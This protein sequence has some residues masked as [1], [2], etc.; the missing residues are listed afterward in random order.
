MSDRVLLVGNFLSGRVGTRAVVEEL[1][2]RLAESGWQVVTTSPQMGRISRMVDMVRTVWGRRSDYDVA[3]IDVFS[4][5]SFVW[6]EVVA[7]LLR[8]L[9]KPY[10]L[11]LRGGNLPPFAARWPGRVRRLLNSTPAV[12]TPS[13]YIL[14]SM[15]AY[16]PHLERLANP[17]KLDAYPYTHRA[18]AQPKLAWLRAFHEIYDPAM[19]VKAVAALAAEFPDVALTMIGPDKGDGT[20]QAMQATA[21]QLGVSERVTIT[22]PVPKP[23]VPGRLAPHDIFINTTTAESF[24]VSVMEAAALGQCIVTTNVGELP[25][26]WQDGENALLVDS[27]DAAAMAD[28]IGRIVRDPAL[29]AQL[30]AGARAN[31]AQYNWTTILPQWESILRGLVNGE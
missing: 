24:G 10:M 1:A 31:A 25:Y 30:S 20:L 6:A 29:A 2:V 16:C 13:F 23:E 18:A 21:D 5:L 12:Y 27:G 19:A 8:R 26:L 22:G 14:E 28:A 9:N 17:L 11:I 4:G 3:Q 15:R 7:W